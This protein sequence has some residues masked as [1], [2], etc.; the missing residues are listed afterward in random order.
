MIPFL[1]NLSQSSIYTELIAI[2]RAYD[3][4]ASEYMLH[5]KSR[6]LQYPSLTIMKSSLRQ[7][8]SSDQT[9]HIATAWQHL[10]QIDAVMNDM[11][12]C[13]KI[14]WF[15]IMSSTGAMWTWLNTICVEFI[16][17]VLA[18]VETD[19]SWIK[20]LVIMVRETVSNG[21]CDR[22]ISPSDVDAYLTGEDYLFRMTYPV[23]GKERQ[24]QRV[25]THVV[26]VIQQWLGYPT[27][28]MSNYQGR[29]VSAIVQDWSPA[30]LYLDATWEAFNRV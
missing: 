26:S 11:A 12:L 7:P 25:E 21:V 18:D 4:S 3:R 2:Q 14:H 13:T 9:L 24:D 23:Y 10:K 20:K 1:G 19:D 29:F 17:A 5:P 28:C 27:S 8:F 6:D 30:V 16:H 22:S 15:S